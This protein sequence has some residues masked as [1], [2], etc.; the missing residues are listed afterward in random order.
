MKHFVFFIFLFA[1]VNTHAAEICDE[2][3]PLTE[4]SITNEGLEKILG[5]SIDQ[6]L[7]LLDQTVK[8][9]AGFKPLKIDKSQCKTKTIS[10]AWKNRKI[11]NCFGLPELNEGAVVGSNT[12]LRPFVAQLEDFK[13]D[14][15]DFELAAPVKC[16]KFV[17]DFEI[18]AKS[19]QVSGNL[20]VDYADKPEEFIPSTP[21]T[22]NSTSDADLRFSG[23]AYIDPKSGLI[24]DLAHIDEQKSKIKMSPGSLMLD[25]KINKTFASKE[26]EIRIKAKNFHRY[27]PIHKVD[28][29]YTEDAYNTA[30]WHM[31]I[32]AERS[33]EKKR[34]AEGKPKLTW[35][36]IREQATAEVDSS[37]IAKYGSIKQF[38]ANLNSI[39]WPSKDDDQATYDFIQNPPPELA[40]FPDLA[41][42]IEFA[43]I[44]A[45]GENSGFSNGGAFALAL[46][47]VNLT[48][49]IGSNQIG[50]NEFIQPLIEKEV[51]PAV[52]A[53]VNN[54]LKNLKKY[55]NQI[56]KI[57]NL[58]AQNMQVLSDL[59]N[60][61]K[62]ASP[63]EATQIQ[64]EIDA[65]KKK[66]ESDWISIDTEVAIDQSTR[67]GKLLR[68]QISKSNPACQTVP[69]KFS[70][71]ED[72][73]FD[74]RTDFG[75]NTLQ[76][77]FNRMAENK[78]LSLCVDSSDAVSC[79]GG[80]RVHIKNPPKISC[81]NGDFVFDI[82]AAASRSIFNIDL[83]G[84]VKAKVNNCS[85][86]P[87]IQFT[88]SSGKFKNVFINTFFGHML[89]RGL[90]TA[91]SKTN[92]V[93]LTIPTVAL[94]KAQTSKQNCNTK[95]DWNIDPA[96]QSKP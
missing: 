86:S 15:I 82:D 44:G 88:D 3:A 69:K 11:D 70:D 78:N 41:E 35:Q 47:A 28:A 5:R 71:D 72:S 68:A 76:E 18:K 92:N 91:L 29:K 83:K 21:L 87:C 56:S 67:D 22:I 9:R 54:E 73:D 25:M 12:L 14:K 58:N 62:T 19:L 59:Q 33:I 43:K 10:E 4:V 89:D 27:V 85:G 60:K 64:I 80:T 81:D 74:V 57:P 42:K 39:K 94:K 13:L 55:W 38:K 30:H 51:L 2:C 31:A 61:L 63:A 93:P 48:N 37:I 34:Q 95:L 40:V 1:F 7:K 32:E 45:I 53:E 8:S 17:C 24:N 52:H 6:N 84:S 90:S 36:Q 79:K 46:T 49:A 16:K 50:I 65:L 23:Q 77:F 96:S 26:E 75:V 20:K 66:M